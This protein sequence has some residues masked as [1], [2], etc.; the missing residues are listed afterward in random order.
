MPAARTKATTGRF[1]QISTVITAGSAW[2]GD[3]SHSCGGM[4]TNPM[5]A[6]ITPYGGGKRGLFPPA[7]PDGST[8]RDRHVPTV[9]TEPERIEERVD[10]GQQE[11]EDRRRKKQ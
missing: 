9:E 2:L 5:R 7:E 4:P 3:P 8:V 11:K 6:V 10:G 1:C